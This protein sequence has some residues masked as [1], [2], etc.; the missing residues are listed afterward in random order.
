[1]SLDIL[2]LPGAESNRLAPV[3]A[4][5]APLFCLVLLTVACAL[6]SF[7]FACATPF[8]AFAVVAAA[9]LPLP[10]ALLVMFTAW[11]VNQAIGFGALHYP[12]DLNTLLWG[13]AIGAAALVATA[14]SKLV[15]RS[16]PRVGSPVMLSLAL[17]GA[18]AAYEVVLF[19]FTPVLG[20]AG[21]FTLAIVGRLGLLNLPWLIGLVAACEVFRLL[22]PTSRRRTVS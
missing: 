2:P 13:L 20:G 8:A 10:T 12:L 9:M 3:E 17:I 5:V 15:L 16:L 7:A 14:A 22:N 4:G 18:Y 1:M 21:A 6:A 11:V 19:S